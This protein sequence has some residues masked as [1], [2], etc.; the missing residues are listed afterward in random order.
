MGRPDIPL[1]KIVQR[2]LLPVADSWVDAA[3]FVAFFVLLTLAP[4]LLR[5]RKPY[6]H[7]ARR[8]MQAVSAFI[9]II[10]LHRC[11]CMLRGWVFALKIVG[12][13]DIIAF[14]HLCMFVLLVAFTLRTGRTFC[15]WVCPLGFFNELVSGIARRRSRLPRRSRLIAGYLMLAGVAAVVFWLAYLARPGTQYFS[16]NVA[17]VWGAGLLLLVGL[18]L[19]F[20]FH[21]RGI[22]RIK[23]VSMLSWIGLSAVGVFVTSPWC[24]LFGDELDYSSGVAL[25]SVLLAGTV[26]AMSWCRYLCPMGAALG[27][28]AKFAPLRLVHLGTCTGCGK[29]REMCPMGALEN[30]RIDQA[31][32]IYCNECV[33]TC[34]FA[35]C[36]VEAERAA[37]PLSLSAKVS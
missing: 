7:I 1:F 21:D 4:W 12:R 19:P 17:A 28:L 31:S 10:F 2:P 18:A 5:R 36:D 11:L 9:F 32:C 20:E 13:N 23:Y 25:I 30:G 37:A 26:L 22:K 33:G 16:E 8:A 14:G 3:P 29:C 34:G 15:G 27:W 24:T 6:A 35:W